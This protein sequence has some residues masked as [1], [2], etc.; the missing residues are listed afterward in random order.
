MFDMQERQF[1]LSSLFKKKKKKKK[2][3]T[4]KKTVLNSPIGPLPVYRLLTVY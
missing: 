4:F 1:S 2:K 3:K